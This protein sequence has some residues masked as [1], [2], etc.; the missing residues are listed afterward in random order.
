ML[1]LSKRSILR[2]ELS[3]LWYVRPT[4]NCPSGC[5]L[6]IS[7]DVRELVANTYAQ[8][9]TGLNE[10]DTDSQTTSFSLY[11]LIY[12]TRCNSDDGKWE[13]FCRVLSSRISTSCARLRN[14]KIPELHADSVPR[15]SENSPAPTP[16][17]NGG[18]EAYASPS[19]SP[20]GSPSVSP[21]RQ[22]VVES[23]VTM[24]PPQ[25]QQTLQPL[26]NPAT[27]PGT[28]VD[29]H[30]YTSALKEHGDSHGTLVA[31]QKRSLNHYPPS[32][33]CVATFGDVTGEGIARNSQQAKHIASKQVCEMLGL[34]VG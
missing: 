12:S 17:T 24:T 21:H 6:T 22:P 14:E 25:A 9:V 33:Q 5:G 32:W 2:T 16:R 28:V 13:D 31:Y 1:R 27:V 23:S 26:A 7:K 8:D 30:K 18:G 3:V 10:G 4:Y 11:S 34:F 15:L 19:P 29:M 20:S